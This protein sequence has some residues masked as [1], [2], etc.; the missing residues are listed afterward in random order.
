ML[1]KTSTLWLS[2]RLHAQAAHQLLTFN[3]MLPKLPIGQQDF[4]KIREEGKLYIDKT[5]EIYALISSGN[6]YFLA[7]P[8]RFGKSLTLSTISELF[9]GNKELFQGLWVE[10]HWNWE[11][12]NPVVHIAFNRINYKDQSLTEGLRKAL[13]REYKKF[14]LQPESNIVS[15][16]F[17]DLLSQ[18]AATRGRV[19]ILIDEYD[20]PLIDFLSKE[21]L[22]Q[23]YE[24]QSILRS[25]YSII[26]SSDSDIQ[27]L[28]ITGVSKFSKVGVFSDLNNLNDITLH[29]HYNTLTGITQEELEQAFGKAIDDYQKESGIGNV[30]D[31]LREWYNGYS[32]FDGTSKVYNPFSILSF[33]DRWSLSNFWFTT[34]TPS[35]LVNLMR[36]R[37]YY[38][39]EQEQVSPAAFE[40]YWLDE[41]QTTALLFQTG[42]LTIKDYS[43]D[44]L[45]YT[46]DFPNREV[47]DSML[48][49]LIGAYSHRSPL[50][51]TPAV[52]QLHA[53]FKSNDLAEVRQLINDLFQTIPHQLFIDAKENLY[54][55]IIHL[56][57]TYLGQYTNAEVSVLR[58]R[59]DAV[60][61]TDTHVYVL[62]F[63]L[64][65][66]A[67]AALDQIHERGYTDAQRSSGKKVVCIGV[68][69][70]SEEKRIDGWEVV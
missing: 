26:K 64:D 66:S 17:E 31:Q 48:Q 13:V 34:G 50:Q 65:G 52:V 9:A 15:E 40:S 2:Y 51:T 30:R 59:V 27:F 29:P 42:Y 8:R 21:N 44:L 41:L 55:A 43:P 33:F 32:F 69:F 68:N 60:V 20:K 53:A 25:F 12:T 10:N 49:H 22:P 23:A 58:G 61:Q 18:L 5:K 28:L 7:R 63:K 37:N 35:F 4:R 70:S 47:K 14:D 6:Y 67:Q 36:E 45:T 46:L 57:F 1:A 11:K 39:F 3:A 16:L 19:V 56:L 24:H 54:H 38:K 62:E